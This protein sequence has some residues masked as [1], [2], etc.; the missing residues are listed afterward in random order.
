MGARYLSDHCDR[1]EVSGQGNNTACPLP[2][3]PKPEALIASH[4][5]HPTTHAFSASLY[6]SN[7]LAGS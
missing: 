2:T 3:S 7:K 6:H 5:S 4:R 1:V